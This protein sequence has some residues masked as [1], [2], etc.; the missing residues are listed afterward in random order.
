MRLSWLGK[1]SKHVSLDFGAVDILHGKDGHFYVLEVNTAPEVEGE[2][3]QV[4]QSLADKIAAWEKNGILEPG[5][6][7]QAA[8][9][10][11]L[12]SQRDKREV[13]RW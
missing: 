4:I 2:G 6:E 11:K 3:R 5:R 13:R 12:P 1:P 8:A 10:E 9:E 7:V